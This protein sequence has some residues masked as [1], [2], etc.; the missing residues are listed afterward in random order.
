MYS[1][2]V[3]LKNKNYFRVIIKN[4]Q[5][6]ETIIISWIFTFFEFWFWARKVYCRL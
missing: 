2:I 6:N 5:Y 3:E 1:I 4:L